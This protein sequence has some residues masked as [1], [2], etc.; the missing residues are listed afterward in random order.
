MRGKYLSLCANEDSV[1]R[2]SGGGIALEK[3]EGA[4]KDSC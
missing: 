3:R 2:G 4:E 1:D